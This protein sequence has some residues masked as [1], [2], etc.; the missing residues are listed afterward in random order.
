ML[1]SAIL[2]RLEDPMIL[3]IKLSDRLHNLRTIY[4]LEP[5]KQKAM[6]RETLNV[7][8]KLAER[9][10]LFSLEA[11]LCHTLLSRCE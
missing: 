6:A 5:E 8:C 4:A 10:G 2:K 1:R 3:A 9:L 7:F 11:R